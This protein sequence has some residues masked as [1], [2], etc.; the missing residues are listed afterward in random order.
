MDSVQEFAS[1]NNNAKRRQR[2]I[3]YT[4]AIAMHRTKKGKSDVSG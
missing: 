2:I 3:R 4:H 1:Y